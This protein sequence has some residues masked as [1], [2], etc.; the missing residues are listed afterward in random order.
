MVFVKNLKREHEILPTP[1]ANM[2]DSSTQIEP[3]CHIDEDVEDDMI[4]H[5]ASLKDFGVDDNDK[6]EDH[7]DSEE[8]LLETESVE[9]ED[10]YS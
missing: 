6:I 5:M 4:H 1:H 9:N 8:E 3:L 2:F 7:D 10:N